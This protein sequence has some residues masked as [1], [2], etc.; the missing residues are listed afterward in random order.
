MKNILINCAISIIS[1]IIM[2]LIAEG[3][4]RTKNMDMKNYNIEMWKYTKELKIKSDDVNLAFYHKPSSEAILQSV[5][6]RT[7]NYGLRGENIAKERITNRRILFLGSSATLG[8]GVDEENIMTTLL[9]KKFGKDVEILNAGVGNYNSVRYTELFFTKLKELEPTDIVVHF[10]L[11]DADDLQIPNTNWFLQ[12]SQLAVLIWNAFTVLASENDSLIN[13][14]DKLYDENYVGYKN[15]INSLDK[16][17]KYSK[18]NNIRLYFASLPDLHY[19]EDDKLDRY[20]KRVQ[21]IV[22]SKGFKFLNLQDGFD[23]GIKSKDLWVMPTDAHPNILA[24]KLMAEQIYPF[25]IIEN[26]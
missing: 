8:W 13:Y 3:L 19:L 15:M 1:I 17:S 5:K 4:I 14:Y 7:N 25:L 20:Y 18:E 26:K 6:I 2:F 11:N 22:I 16:L 10:F 23:K 24:H 12:N 9:A 21:E